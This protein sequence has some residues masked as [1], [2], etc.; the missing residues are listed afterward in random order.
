MKKGF[1]SNVTS[2]LVTTNKKRRKMEQ[3]SSWKGFPLPLVSTSVCL[4]GSCIWGESE[5][6]AWGLGGMVELEGKEWRLGLGN[7]G[8]WDG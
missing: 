5:R 4:F 3:K 2:L 1:R 8:G 7:D 6:K